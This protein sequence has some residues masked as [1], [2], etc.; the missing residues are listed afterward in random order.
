MRKVIATLVVLAAFSLNAIAQKEVSGR[1]TDNNNQ[2]VSGASIIVKGTT[3]GTASNA[4]GFFTLM[5]P[6]NGRVLIVSSVNMESKEVVIGERTSIMVSLQ[7]QA[8]DLTNV[9]VTVPYGTVKKK[10]FTG[11]ENTIT[12]ATLQKQQVTNITKALEGQVSGVIAT[13]GGGAP[14]SAAG[15]LIRGVGSVNATSAPLYVLN[16]VPYDGSISALNNDDIESITVLK[17][18]AAAALYGARAANGVVMITTKKGRKGTPR[19]TANVRQGFMTRL[20]P[21][22]DRVGAKDY[23]EVFWEAYRNSYITQGQSAAAAGISASNVLTSNNGL[24]YNAYNVAGNKLVDSIT[25]KIN[26]NARLLWNESWEEAMFRTASRTNASLSFS[27]GGEGADYYLSASYLNEDGIANYSGYKLWNSR[28]NVNVSPKT[29]FNAGINIDGGFANRRDVPSGG[30][31]TT[32]PFYYTR[33]MGPIY[34]VYQHNLTSGA[35]VIDSATGNPK[36]DFGV[37]EQMGTRPYAGRSNVAATLDLDERSSKIFNGNANIFGEIKFLKDFSFKGTLGINYL[38]TNN[39]TYQNNQY[40]DAAPSTPGG[41]DG[42]RSTKSNDRAIS[43]TGNQVLSWNKIIAGKH[44][45]RALV[46]HENYRYKYNYLEGSKSGFIFPGY[47]D[48]DNGATAT[49]PASSFENNHT[50]ESYFSNVNYDYD[51]RYLLSASYRTDGSSRFA[52]ATRWGDFYSVGLGWRISGEKFMDGIKKTV[53]ELKLRASYG[54]QGNENIGL[55]YTYNDYYFAN[56]VGGYTPPNPSRVANKELQWETNSVLNVGMDFGLLSNRITGTVEWFKRKSANLLFDVPLPISTGFAQVYQNIGAMQNTG[57]ELQL[58]I[59][60]IRRADFRWRVDFNITS[61]KNKITKL[62]PNQAKNGIISGTKKL[63]EGGGIFDFWLPEF[64]GV[65][66]STGDALYYVDIKDSTGKIIGTETTNRYSVAS[67]SLRNFGSALPKFAGGITNTF[68]FKGFD[69]SV[70]TTFSYGGKFYDGNYA[71][72]MHR[73]SAG[74]AWHTDILK[75]WQNPG[76]V[77]NVPR[78]ENNISNQDGQSSRFL[79]DGSWL[80]IKNVTLSY[81]LPK[82]IT[83]RLKINGLQF[84]VNVDNAWLFTAKKGADPQRAFNGTADATYTP[85]RTTSV[86]TTINF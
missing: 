39:T 70:L 13:N 55:L 50:I 25:G 6:K 23:Y 69:L 5:V 44:N 21:E 28:I 62:P 20:I 9:V 46:G 79:V 80:A 83:E 45:V 65:D 1:V 66:A 73:G 67:G 76:D 81:S 43:L 51:G 30:T 49:N 35:I 14:G 48:L 37:P 18:A 40:G 41:A 3:A 4:D 2:P 64:A 84:F 27:G 42:G 22:Y 61:F 60:A 58:G 12:S 54:E 24:V 82:D 32:N 34:P 47:T 78:V 59:A 57:V 16:G 86:G 10:A 33:Q 75:R 36:Y 7:P 26:P 68:T 31:A 71:S 85:F 56:G 8:G 77:T 19:M 38:A 29:W 11:A 74:T 15:I 52:P 17:D 72:I 63:I 53:N